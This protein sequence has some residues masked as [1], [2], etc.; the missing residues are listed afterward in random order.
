MDPRT[1]WRCARKTR[2]AQSRCRVAYRVIVRGLSTR[3]ALV[4]ELF[5]PTVPMLSQARRWVATIRRIAREEPRKG[6]HGWK[7]ATICYPAELREVITR[8]RDEIDAQSIEPR[9]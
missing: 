9:P 6:R 2:L 7:L 5:E 8:A 3:E 1:F 4:A